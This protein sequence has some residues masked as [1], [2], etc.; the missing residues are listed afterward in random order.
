M[1]KLT[2]LERNLTFS[3][4]LEAL[5]EK[6]YIKVPEWE[7]YWFLR[8]GSIV[9]KTFDGQE[10][11]TPW[12]KETVLREDWQIVDINKEWENEQRDL[13]LNSFK[14]TGIHMEPFEGDIIEPK[15]DLSKYTGEGRLNPDEQDKQNRRNN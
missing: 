7:G 3:R 15:T 1:E 6:K 11:G 12:L 9:V 5:K 4:A 10:L 8:S 14:Q 2:I 13:I